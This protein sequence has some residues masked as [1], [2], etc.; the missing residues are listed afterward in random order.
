MVT[1]ICPRCQQRFNVDRFTLDFVHQ[2]HSR[3]NTLDNEDVKVV[4]KWEDFTGSGGVS[5]QMA[6]MQGVGDALWGTRAFI[7]GERK[8]DA[9]VRGNNASTSRK[10]QHFEF[11]EINEK[12]S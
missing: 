2:C 12:G 8:F 9:T 10:R 4:G 6:M 5:K 3:N 1:K 11:I 7:E